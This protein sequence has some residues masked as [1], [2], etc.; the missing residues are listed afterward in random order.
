MLQLEG[1]LAL[2]P[3]LFLL[4]IL[5][6][7]FPFLAT[8]PPDSAQAFLTSCPDQR[9]NPLSELSKLSPNCVHP[10]HQPHTCHID[11]PKAEHWSHHT[12]PQRF[13]WF[14]ITDKTKRT[15]RL[16]ILNPLLSDPHPSPLN[17]T[18]PHLVYCV[19]KITMYCSAI[20]FVLCRFLF[21]VARFFRAREHPLTP[22]PQNSPII[23]HLSK[24]RAWLPFL[25]LLILSPPNS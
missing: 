13:Q 6:P 22:S 16:S 24:M 17:I 12:F 2:S 5:K 11:S 18:S 14:S 19:R 4:D 3:G 8:L 10:F 7:L 1:L 23:S 9:S 20:M 15:S 25:F 21:C